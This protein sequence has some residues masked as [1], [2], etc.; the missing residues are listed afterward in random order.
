MYQV[1]NT[2]AKTGKLGEDI[3]R[4]DAINIY[5]NPA[6]GLLRIEAPGMVEIYNSTGQLVYSGTDQVLDVS[7]WARGFYIVRSNDLTE[8]LLIN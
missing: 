3:S 6:N 5:P 8:R 7:Q 4:S 2:S 1:I